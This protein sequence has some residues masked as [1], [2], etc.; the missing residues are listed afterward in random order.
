MKKNL[1]FEELSDEFA[2]FPK[3]ETEQKEMHG[4][5]SALCFKNL[6]DD[7]RDTSNSDREE[8]P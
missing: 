1:L 6:S 7:I 3:R 2:F 8:S 5:P 4:Y